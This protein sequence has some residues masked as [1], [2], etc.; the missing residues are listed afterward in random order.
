MNDHTE[1]TPD[2]A[3]RRS[4]MAHVPRAGLPRAITPPRELKS[5][6]RELWIQE[7]VPPATADRWLADDEQVAIAR[8]AS[9]VNAGVPSARLLVG[10][11]GVLGVH[12]KFLANT[13]YV[14]GVN[15]ENA[16][17]E[18]RLRRVA[19]HLRLAVVRLDVLLTFS[20]HAPPHFSCRPGPGRPQ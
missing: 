2:S 7:G 13:M 5:Q 20:T 15:Q 6:A 4:Q 19:Y 3:Q 12:S 18:Y 14:A 8:G 17:R 10:P 1:S 11:T 9:A 16:N